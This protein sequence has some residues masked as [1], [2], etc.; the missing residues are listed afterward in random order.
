VIPF[1]AGHR[2]SEATLAVFILTEVDNIV[3]RP[4][5]PASSS[6]FSALDKARGTLRSSLRRTF[7]FVTTGVRKDG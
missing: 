2:R 3:N 1:D 4:N 7:S 5:R 6:G